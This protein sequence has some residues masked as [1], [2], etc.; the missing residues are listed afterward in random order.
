MPKHNMVSTEDYVSQM[1]EI[2]YVD[3][4]LEDI[5]EDVF[6]GFVKFLKGRGWGWWVFGAVIETYARV[7][8]RFIVVSGSKGV[9]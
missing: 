5:T 1:R 8:A 4:V 6:P 3:I 7:G 9:L 2:G